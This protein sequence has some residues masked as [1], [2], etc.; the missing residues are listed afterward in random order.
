M[1]EIAQASVRNRLL[2]ALQPEQFARLQPLL[3]RVSLRLRE[4]LEEP[5]KPIEHVYF[6]EPGVVSVVAVSQGGER[7][8]VGVIGPE[9]MTGLPIVNGTDR[10]PHSVFIQMPCRALRIRSDDLRRVIDENRMLHE[11]FLRYA[12]AFSVQVMQTALVNGRYPLNERLARWLLMTND[13]AEREDLTLTHEFL[14]LMLGVRRAGITTALH[15]FE[16]A[17]ILRAERGLIQLL[18][19]KRLEEAAGDAYGVPEAEYE[20]LMGSARDAT[21]RLLARA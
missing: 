9:G 18:D 19:R 14:A 17:G 7:L 13:R 15:I 6:P 21:T 5:R 4:E 3:V 2:S 20:R 16:S 10:S 12:Q 8:E 1:S 11:R